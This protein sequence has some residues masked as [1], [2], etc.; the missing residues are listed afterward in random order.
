MCP[1]SNSSGSHGGN[2]SSSSNGKRNGTNYRYRTV[3]AQSEVDETLFGTPHRLTTAAKMRAERQDNQEK[4]YQNT[5]KQVGPVKKEF[6]R[7]IT[8]DLIR[9][10]M[11]I[12][13]RKIKLKHFFLFS[14]CLVFP[15]IKHVHRLFLM[16]L[17]INVYL[18]HLVQDQNK[19]GNKKLK[20]QN[21]VEKPLR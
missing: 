11:Y 10:I 15:K 6:V 17:H 13:K 16:V 18:M 3:N 20:N 8:K 21:E 9:D 12:Y 2:G 7:H 5:T 1:A 19:Y 14:I 4:Q